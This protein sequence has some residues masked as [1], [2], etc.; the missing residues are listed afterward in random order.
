MFWIPVGVIV[1][2]VM[3]VYRCYQEIAPGSM[4]NTLKKEEQISDAFYKRVFNGDLNRELQKKYKQDD[5]QGNFKVICD[6]MGRKPVTDNKHPFITEWQSMAMAT[7]LCKTGHLP[8][9]ALF[10]RIT[11]PSDERWER[12]FLEEFWLKVESEL[13]KRG[14]KTFLVYITPDN[15]SFYKL[16]EFR[17]KFGNGKTAPGGRVVWVNISEYVLKYKDELNI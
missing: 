12:D 4:Q 5:Y 3:L 14:V 1:I 15:R 16:S 7:E 8:A 17:R 11:M 9:S 6:F 13:Q 2:I 10:G